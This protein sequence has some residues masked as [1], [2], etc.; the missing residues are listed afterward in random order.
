MSLRTKPIAEAGPTTRGNDTT[1]A[2]HIRAKGKINME[3]LTTPRQWIAAL[4]HGKVN[5]GDVITN[6]DRLGDTVFEEIYYGAP[7][8]APGF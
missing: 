6:A 2:V 5:W 7:S 4:E 3:K 1:T 8:Y